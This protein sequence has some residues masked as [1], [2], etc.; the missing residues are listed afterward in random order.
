MIE[1]CVTS[2]PGEG[3]LASLCDIVRC[4]SINMIKSLFLLQKIRLTREENHGIIIN[5]T[6]NKHFF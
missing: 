5:G 1:V 2:N 6:G 3:G 4:W